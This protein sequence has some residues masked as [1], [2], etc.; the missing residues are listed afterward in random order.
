VLAQIAELESIDAVLISGDLA[1]HG[2]AAEY[3]QLFAEIPKSMAALL[4]PGNHDLSEP[5]LR[6][7]TAVGRPPALNSV[8]D[9]ADVR[10]IGLDSHIDH[11]D[12]GQ[13]AEETLAYAHEKISTAKGRVILAMHHPP[14]H[15]GHPVM[16]SIA[17]ANAD[18]L[19]ALITDHPNVIG[20]LTGHL[21]RA[22]A[23]TFA[24]VALVGAPGIASTLRLGAM[25][26]PLLDTD[27]APG[28]ALHSVHEGRL[29][30]TFH[31][32]SPHGW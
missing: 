31:H 26:E 25:P 22:L 19:A 11:V 1:D 8:L 24:G 13:L 3:E 5:L 32:L 28:F 12:G 7:L 23:T 27:A 18:A 15:I 10:L 20:V 9:V 29:E 4:I 2:R 21:H 16:D 14:V 6:G 30:S 17:L